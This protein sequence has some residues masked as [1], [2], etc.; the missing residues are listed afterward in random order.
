[1]STAY[2]TDAGSQPAKVGSEILDRLPP[3]NLDAEKGVLGSIL[4]DPDM[5]DDVALVVRPEDFYAEANE[6]LFRHLLAMHDEGSRIDSTLL[7]ERLRSAGD[8]ER[9]GGAA[10]LAEVVHA[11]PY[12]ANAVHYAEIVRAKSTL[13]ALIHA[14]TEIL[15]DAYEPTLDRNTAKGRACP[16]ASRTS[17][18]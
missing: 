7:L 18:P 16:P 8:L 3:Q 4:L 15:R 13:R 14:S 2:R 17:T 6:K 11:V 12:A 1:M 10:Y 9:I 5:A